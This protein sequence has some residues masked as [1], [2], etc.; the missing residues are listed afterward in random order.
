MSKTLYDILLL[1]NFFFLAFALL[2]V[3]YYA[4]RLR[5]ELKRSNSLR[6]DAE[7]FKDLFN[8]TTEGVFQFD[9]EGWFTIMNRSG[10]KIIG[11]E[12]TQELLDSKLKVT[13]FL[14]NPSDIVRL[15]RLIT[16]ENRI[17]NHF[18]KIRKKM[19]T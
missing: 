1:I 9:T 17:Q 2:C 6:A 5:I 7:N 14:Y 19:A 18:I 4:Y 12:T 3:Y 10:T 16:K 8:S 15:Y 13:Q 11:F